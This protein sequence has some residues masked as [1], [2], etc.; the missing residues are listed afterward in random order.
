M[1]SFW[2]EWIWN[3]GFRVLVK[4]YSESYWSYM[5]SCTG[6]AEA[7]EILKPKGLCCLVWPSKAALHL[8]YRPT[9]LALKRCAPVLMALQNRSPEQ[10]THTQMVDFTNLNFWPKAKV[11]QQYPGNPGSKWKFWIV[12]MLDSKSAYRAHVPWSWIGTRSL[13]PIFG[14]LIQNHPLWM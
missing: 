1:N 3:V 10:T 4:Q 2:L 9:V 7:F 8:R 14:E 12:L 13:F 5:V 6:N 11:F